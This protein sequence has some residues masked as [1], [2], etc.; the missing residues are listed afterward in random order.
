MA[1]KI[2]AGIGHHG[3][4]GYSA[5]FDFSSTI[6]NAREHA[7]NNSIEPLHILLI[8]PGDIRHILTTISKRRRHKDKKNGELTSI[9]FYILESPMEV[10]ARNI[11]LMEVMN[12]FEVP[13]RQRTNI[14]L[15]IYG[16]CKVQE[17][18]GRYIEQLGHELRS[19]VANSTGR[20]EGLVDLSLLRYRDK[21]ELE[22][23][24]KSYR[25]SNSF[26][27]ETYRNHRLRGFYAERYDS[28]IALSDWDYHEA[29]HSRA[30]IIH[31]KQYKD[32]RLSGIAF[33]FG[34]QTYS[35][36][37]RTMMSYTEGVL[38]SG[39]DKG[40][41]KEV[42]GYWGDIVSSPYFTY[43][44]DCEGTN[45]LSE[46]L[47]EIL[48]KNTGAE[49]HRHHAVEVAVY[50]LLSELWE[51]ETGQIYRM[52][53]E[54]D[55]YSGLGSDDQRRL[56]TTVVSDEKNTGV[57]QDAENGNAALKVE[58]EL[59]V[60]PIITAEKE[61][62]GE[63]D[64]ENE[65]AR[66]IKRAECIVEAF[67]D[68]KVFPMKGSARDV[69][70]KPKYS[71]FFDAVF[72]S[73]RAAQVI[74]EDFFGGILKDEGGVVAVETAKFFTQMPK[75]EQKEEFV[76]KVESYASKHNLK[77]LSPP[78]FRR[79]RDENDLELDVIFFKK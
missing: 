16:N 64:E 35:D 22:E 30:S 73:S 79:A 58:E 76:A 36:P 3:L 59:Q 72:V 75:K 6:N 53:K 1:S 15:E 34:D 74:N 19:L 67:K 77:K 50:N 14:F 65:L 42:K 21:D 20:L 18:T 28:R 8:N 24:F 31:I 9:Y 27:V 60:V 39:A 51:I 40:Y 32:W 69:L 57:S 44:I 61:T 70:N 23:C 26:D 5:T 55:I 13:I 52:T 48:S 62:K 12:D 25:L 17:R 4:W 7:T 66:S 63:K 37:N 43:G 10:I 47:F 29:I 78:V 49:Q 33:E 2:I 11:L 68:V 56:P 45:K 41:K 46:G 71:N 38:K 54:H